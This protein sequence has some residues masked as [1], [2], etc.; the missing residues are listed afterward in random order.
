MDG[1]DAP[2]GS[3]CINGGDDSEGSKEADESDGVGEC[4]ERDGD[5]S[6][7]DVTEVEMYCCE[8]KRVRGVRGSTEDRGD[9][10]SCRASA[11]EFAVEE[12]GDASRGFEYMPDGALFRGD[13]RE[14]RFGGGFEGGAGFVLV[15]VAR[16]DGTHTVDRPEDFEFIARKRS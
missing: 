3:D 9:G 1:M 14:L 16:V 8:T 12:G 5:G 10:F 6:P 11:G 7:D 15:M 13:G 4:E 2:S